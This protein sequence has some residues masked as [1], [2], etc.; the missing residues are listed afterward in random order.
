MEASC[1]ILLIHLPVR[2]DGNSIECIAHYFVSPYCFNISAA[3]GDF[4][5]PPAEPAL[6]APL[7]V[8]CG[9]IENPLLIV[10]AIELNPPV[11]VEVVADAA[12]VDAVPIPSGDPLPPVPVPVAVLVPLV[13]LS[14]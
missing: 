5:A 7:F 4:P 6:L 12:E 11:E 1:P 14:R 9:L 13:P 10:R 2:M 3:L 8:F